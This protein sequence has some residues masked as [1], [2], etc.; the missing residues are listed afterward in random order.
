MVTLIVLS[1]CFASLSGCRTIKVGQP[2]SKAFYKI[3]KGTDIDGTPSDR[4]GYFMDDAT[5]LEEFEI[6]FE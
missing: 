4:D 6:E 3:L 1:V 2:D 5:L